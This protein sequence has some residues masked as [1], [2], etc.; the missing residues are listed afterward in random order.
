M[1]TSVKSRSTGNFLTLEKAQRRWPV[2][3]FQH[4]VAELP[5]ALHGVG[6]DIVIVFD[7]HDRLAAAGRFGR[8]LHGAAIRLIFYVAD[9][10]RQVDLDGGSAAFL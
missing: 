7:D 5:K 4:P 6:A 1:T 10:A 2:V 3:R 8:R 9:E